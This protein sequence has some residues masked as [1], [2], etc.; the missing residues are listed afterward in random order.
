[1]IPSHNL[2][3]KVYGRSKS[4]SS[5]QRNV[6]VLLLPSANLSFGISAAFYMSNFRGACLL[7]LA[8][9]VLPASRRFFAPDRSTNPPPGQAQVYTA[10]EDGF[11]KV[12]SSFRLGFMFEDAHRGLSVH[13]SG[14]GKGRKNESG[15]WGRFGRARLF[16]VFGWLEYNQNFSTFCQK[17][18]PVFV[19]ATECGN[20]I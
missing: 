3:R 17:K 8:I 18:L 5:R 15:R 20:V 9:T 10:N 1:M 14:P 7:Q 12:G 6:L 13:S 2:V 11:A 4:D 19:L 16:K